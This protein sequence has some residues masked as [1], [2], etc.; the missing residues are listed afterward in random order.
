MSTRSD[1]VVRA[2][3]RRIA[4]SETKWPFGHSRCVNFEALRIGRSDASAVGFGRDRRNHLGWLANSAAWEIEKA[5]PGASGRMADFWQ[6]RLF[7]AEQD[8]HVARV[9]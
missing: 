7:A 6:D 5:S 4:A 8:P 1:A 9:H 2:E 3:S